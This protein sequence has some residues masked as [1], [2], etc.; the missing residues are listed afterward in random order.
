MKMKK[1]LL[2]EILFLG[3]LGVAKDMPPPWDDL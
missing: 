2:Y 1:P 3:S